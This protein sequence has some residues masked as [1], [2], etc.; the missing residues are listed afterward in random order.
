MPERSLTR[1][2]ARRRAALLDVERYDIDVDMTGLADGPAWRATSRVRF[3]CAEPGA[4]SFVDCVAEVRSATLNG[5]PL[6]AAAVAQGRIRLAGLAAHN[7]LV[8]ES[9]QQDTSS[10]QGVQRSVDPGDGLVYVWT[11][12]EPDDARRAWACFDQ[13]DL[14]APHAFTVLAPA[15]WTVTSNRAASSVTHAVGAGLGEDPARLWTFPDTPPLSTYVVVVNAGPFHEVRQ[16]RGGHDIGFL[17][18][19]SLAA[20]LDRDAEELF[21]TTV[22]G[23]AFFG[24]RFGQPFGQSRYDTVFIPDMPGAMEN[25]GCVTWGDFALFR[26]A[27]TPRERA[28]RAEILLHE[29]AHMW[30]GDLV[31]MTWWD[32]LWL[33]ESFAEWAAMWACSALTEFADTWAT[34]L[35][36]RKSG[37][38]ASD[39]APTRHPIRQ[40]SRDVA[41]ASASFDAIT[42]AKGASVLK[43]LVALL[44][45]D[46]FLSGLR[47]Y[48]SQHA[49]SNTT[50]ADLVAAL[51]RSSGRD[52]APWVEGWLD[53]AG[54]DRLRLLRDAEGWALHGQG[55]DGGPPRVHRLDVGVYERSGGGWRRRA[56]VPVETTG[57]RTPVSGLDVP[58]GGALLLPNDEDL[59]FA[60]TRPDPESTRLLLAGAGGL[61]SA[62]SRAV[63]TSTFWDM[64]AH[65]ETTTGDYVAVATSAVRDEHEAAVAEVVLRQLVSAVERWAPASRREELT[66]QVAAVAV[67]LAARAPLRDLALRTLARTATSEADLDAVRARAGDDVELAWLLLTRE[68]ELGRYDEGAVAELRRRD[69]DPDSAF[70]ALTVRAAVPEAAA[71]DEVW[72]AVFEDRSVPPDRILGLGPAFWRPGQERLLA[73]YVRRY[74]D[75][76]P[77]L[78]G[79]MLSMLAT[80]RAFFPVTVDDPAEVDDLETAAGDDQLNPILRRGLTEGIDGLRR[81]LRARADG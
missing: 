36:L 56:L 81:M 73:D 65:A 4:E 19:R 35:A 8:V 41:Q 32:D 51:E 22:A 67:E 49:W 63:V 24:E 43:Q 17:C 15:A 48:F 45:E 13:P 12:F 61:P 77:R 69:P 54:T 72:Q 3:G 14:K 79:G 52:L 25:W 20:M 16:E 18:R 75:A 31:T 58:A 59:T 28:F 26:S 11:S 39:R 38:Y 66:A 70:Q 78:E 71:K 1:E 21:A 5:V 9:V 10:R 80:G 46:V 62:M 33:N 34:F 37:G 53:R 2:E 27:P 57:E 47:D 42:Y 30:F 55:P 60:S 76:L 64:L 23:L 50:L 6:P 40:R 7:E 44:G 68:A 74:L 29:M